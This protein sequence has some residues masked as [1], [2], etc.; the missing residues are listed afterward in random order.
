MRKILIVLL[1]LSLLMPT[2]G[3]AFADTIYTVQRGDTLFG[4]ATRFGVSLSSLAAANGISNLN[5]IFVGEQLTIPGT[6]GGSTNP[7]PPPPNGGGRAALIQRGDQL[8]LV[9]HRFGGGLADLL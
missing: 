1:T 5:L 3:S 6:G 9:A 2:A 7:P 8:G 4:I